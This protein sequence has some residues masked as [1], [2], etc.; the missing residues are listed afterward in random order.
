VPVRGL[1]AVVIGVLLLLLLVVVVVLVE[2]LRL[3]C[4]WLLHVIV[5]VGVAEAPVNDC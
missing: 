2:Q 1:A 4:V 3:A 5:R